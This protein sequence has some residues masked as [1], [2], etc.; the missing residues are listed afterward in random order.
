MVI[1]ALA[2]TILGAF[3]AAAQ[4]A[5]NGVPAN[6]NVRSVELDIVGEALYD[7]NVARSDE[8]VAEDR[9][10]TSLQDEVFTPSAR[11]NINLPVGREALFLQSSAGYDFYRI[12]TILNRERINVLGGVTGPTGP[13]RETLTGSYARYQ[14]DLVDLA[15]PE[16]LLSTRNTEDHEAINLDG[17]CGRAI[18]LAP[19]FSLSQAWA[20]NSAV[21]RRV[22]DS[23][24]FSATGGLAYAR[25]ALGSLSVFGEFITTEFP[26]NVLL[27]D[28]M[29]Q[30]DGYQVYAGGLRYD[31]R[32]GARI[33]GVVSLSYTS[34]D[35]A[36]GNDGFRG[37]TY[38]ADGTYQA[39]SRLQAHIDFSRVTTPSNV[40][41][42]SFS[43]D[44]NLLAEGIYAVGPRLSLKLGALRLARHYEG[45]GLV[46]DLDL[47][48]ETIYT[49]YTTATYTLSKRLAFALDL[50][51]EQRDANISAFSYVSTRVGLTATGT[52]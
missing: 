23:R 3:P 18:G 22:V 30:A 37:F 8:A 28:G 20:D 34:L 21:V 49:V 2:G 32:L 46:D 9:G 45:P 25:P 38:S 4:Q 51:R 47:T 40:L 5:A 48:N 10:I 11:L 27:V 33:Q 26:N 50:R 17:T 41:G 44:Q 24:T 7:S 29:P 6:P 52:F 12:N 39:S 36:I 13:C 43:V 15:G 35:P 16:V 14:S 31:R 42:A 1:G 19:T